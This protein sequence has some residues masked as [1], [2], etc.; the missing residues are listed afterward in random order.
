MI[1]FAVE[2]EVGGIDDPCAGS[3]RDYF[4]SLFFADLEVVINEPSWID[5]QAFPPFA[6][7]LDCE[8][9][10]VDFLTCA[11]LHTGSVGRILFSVSAVRHIDEGQYHSW[12]ENETRTNCHAQEVFGIVG[13]DGSDSSTTTHGNLSSSQITFFGANGVGSSSD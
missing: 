11:V 1:T 12:Q 10:K 13:N 9:R 2:F 4:L 8:I 6:H 7:V 3:P 5:W